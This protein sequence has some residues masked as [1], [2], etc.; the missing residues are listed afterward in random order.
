[1]VPDAFIRLLRKELGV[2]TI[3]CVLWG[4]L[5]GVLASVVYRNMSLG[6]VLCAAMLLNLLLA[7]R[8]VCSFRCRGFAWAAI[9]PSAVR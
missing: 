7:A 4:G 8:R 1:V 3:N 2:A 9:L 6:L 5:L